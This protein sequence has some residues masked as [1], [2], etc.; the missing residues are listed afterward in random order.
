MKA[1]RKKILVISIVALLLGGSLLYFFVIRS[2]NE[3][4]QAQTASSDQ[5]TEQTTDDS[6]SDDQN[7][8]SP[9]R[10]DLPTKPELEN[11]TITGTASVTLSFAEQQGGNIV[12]RAFAAADSRGSCELKLT[13]G[14]QSVTKNSGSSFQTS[15]YQCDGFEFSVNDMPS[16]G[17]WT[18]QV[19][20]TD[21]AR[22]VNTSNEIQFEV[23]K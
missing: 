18:A 10:E 22:A 20:Y 19:T 12:A 3:S 13:K 1:S 14:S 8:E 2:S 15:Y 16:G 5:S 4:D 9:D 7:N 6:S 17:T 11:E 21:A 23:T